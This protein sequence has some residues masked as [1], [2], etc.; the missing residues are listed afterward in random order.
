M[1][2]PDGGSSLDHGA[3]S[4]SSPSCSIT[5]DILGDIPPVPSLPCHSP[6]SSLGSRSS[7]ASK[8]QHIPRMELPHL[9]DLSLVQEIVQVTEG[10]HRRAT[11]YPS[12]IYLGVPWGWFYTKGKA[13]PWH[14]RPHGSVTCLSPPWHDSGHGHRASK[15]PQ[16]LG[17]LMT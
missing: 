6:L 3:P 17:A 4:G 15:G 1:R 10:H 13:A 9:G 16:S 2:F 8:A 14:P 12:M 7:P 5:K 11:G